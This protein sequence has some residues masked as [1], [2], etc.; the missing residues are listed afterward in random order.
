MLGGDHSIGF[1]CMRGIAQCTSKKI[2]IIHFD[3]HIDIE[4]QRLLTPEAVEFDKPTAMALAERIGDLEA[5][6]FEVAPFGGQAFLV[7]AVPAAAKGK[8]CAA[9]L[10]EIGAGLVETEGRVRPETLREKLWITAACRM[11]V[12]AGDPLSIVEMEHLLREL[13]STENPYMCPHGRPIT[14]TLTAE[15]L[16]R[17]FKRT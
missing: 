16:L 1:P 14:I 11:A 2:G 8:D 3:R 6:G 4:T 13:A 7:R 5:A 15:E 9:I 12:K 17:R 10:R